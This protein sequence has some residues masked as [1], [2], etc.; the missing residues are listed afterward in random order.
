MIRFT[1][2]ISALALAAA[3][4]QADPAQTY[5]QECAGCHGADRLGGTGPALIP[6]TLKRMRGP[7]L[8]S[9]IAN[10][11][12]ATQMPAFGAELGAGQIAALAAYLREPLEDIPRWGPDR[13][14]RCPR[15][16][17]GDLSPCL[18]RRGGKRR[19]QRPRRAGRPGLA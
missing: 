11:R 2:L 18:A 15:K 1:A 16:I 5:A 17:Q 13:A 10:G 14:E 19:V 9:V 3:A 4:A 8:E 7:N 12:P 6:Q